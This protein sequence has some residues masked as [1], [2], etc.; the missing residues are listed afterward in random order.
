MKRLLTLAG[1]LLLQG[2][3]SAAGQEGQTLT[4]AAAEDVAAF[5]NR[6]ATTRVTGPARVAAGTAVRGDLASLG[7]PLTIAGTVDGDVV[8]INGDV[9][10][11]VGAEITGSLTVV[12][13]SVS[14]SPEAVAGPVTVYTESLEFRREGD[15]I[16]ALEPSGESLLSQTT[17][18][19][20]GELA[21]AVD[22]AYNRVE[23]LPISIGPRFELG[24]TNPTIFDARIIYR[25]GNGFQFHPDELG[26]QVRVEQYLGGH[27]SLLV[28]LGW[29]R[30][31]DPIETRGLSDV[32][33]SISTFVLHRDLRDHYVRSGWEAYL[34]YTARTR[35]LQAGVAYRDEH[36][37][38]IAS[39]TPWSLLD[40][41]EDWRAQP[42]VAEGDIRVVEGWLRWDSRNNQDDPSAGWL[43]EASVEQGVE[44]DLGVLRENPFPGADPPFVR[45]PVNAEYTAARIE[46]RRYLRLGPNTRLALRA[47]AA[48][49]PDD[50]ALPPQRQHALGGEG[51][52]PGYAHFAFDCGARLLPLV[53]QL[54]PYYGCDRLVLFQA[55]YRFAFLGASGLS[56]GRLLGLDFELAT[57]PELV[58][59]AD[60]GRAW[61]EPESLGG[62]AD[63]GLEGFRYDAG[64]GLR[65][66]RIGVYIAAPL[67]EGGGGV[68]FFFRLG[69]RI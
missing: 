10:L 40:N 59:F 7:G 19:G 35:P 46:A 8:V 14:G 16:I 38:S 27:R 68:N 26:H 60:A 41:D 44:G 53:N 64:V 55:E 63:V 39:R 23:G 69:P 36:H 15:R 66:G 24:R 21:L 13:G 4:L 50:G 57:T 45:R 42:Q 33:N 65:M 2:A 18:F 5:Y 25:T 37:S 54:A 17:W 58:L 62:R 22:G 29:H 28:G 20:R 67:S 61:I 34:R 47:L 6:A 48:G 31:T 52:L 51:S 3:A 12:G 9:V 32:E 43:L 1:I 49:S 30:V 11:P 56:L